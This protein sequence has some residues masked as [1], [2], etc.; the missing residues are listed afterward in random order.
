MEAEW[1]A[2]YRFLDHVIVGFYA[3]AFLMIYLIEIEQLIIPDPG[4]FQYPLWPPAR[5]VDLAHWWGANYHGGL[6]FRP[7]WYKATIWVDIFFSGPV[8]LAGIYAFSRKKRWIK[9][10]A[11]IQASMLAVIVFISMYEEI[12]GQYAGDQVFIVVLS[13]ALWLFVPLLVICRAAAIPDR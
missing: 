6:Y 7:A 5:L 4:N 12:W 10:P 11:I 1:P 3:V 8:Y 13:M 9:Y 2:K